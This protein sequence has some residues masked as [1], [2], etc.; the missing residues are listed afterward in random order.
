[1][2]KFPFTDSGVQALQNQLYQ[3]T[4]NQLRTEGD[5]ILLDFSKWLSKH[6]N[7]SDRQLLFIAKQDQKMIGFLATQTAIAIVNRLPVTLIKPISQPNNEL[8]DSK[9]IRPESN[10]SASSNSP[11]QINGKLIIEITY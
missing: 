3:S 4:D 8:A 5:L 7:L 10:F 1:M 2:E 11:S 6:F 9:L